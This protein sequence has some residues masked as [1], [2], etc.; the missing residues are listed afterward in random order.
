MRKRPMIL[1]AATA[2]LATGLALPRALARA[3]A[4]NPVRQTE[5]RDRTVTFAIG[6][7]TCALCPVTVKK[8]MERVAGVRSV[9]VDFRTKTAT[10]VFD[11][12]AT[13]AADVAA[14]A[15]NVGYPARPVGRPGP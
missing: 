13:S 7:M 9:A 3:R 2:L 6:N 12:S 10:V 1:A 14:A 5:A 15:T 11:P 4:A 8:A